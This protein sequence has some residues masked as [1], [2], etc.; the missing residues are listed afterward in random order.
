MLAVPD[1]NVSRAIT[2]LN[3]KPKTLILLVRGLGALF[4]QVLAGYE[5]TAFA[6]GQTGTGKTHWPQLRLRNGPH[7]V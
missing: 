7:H 1:R 4:V 6:Y 3:L 2:S 5:T